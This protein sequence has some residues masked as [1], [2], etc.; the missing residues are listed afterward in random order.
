[1]RKV[2]ST[3]L[4]GFLM[5]L[6]LSATAAL[7]VNVQVSVD[8]KVAQ[9]GDNV[10]I[11]GTI[12]HD[13]GAGGDFGYRVYAV[14]PSRPDGGERVI[15]CDSGRLNTSDSSG[16]SYTC[17]LPTIDGFQSLGLLNA[18]DR[19]VI[20]LKVGVAAIDA[21][22]NSTGK[23]AKEVLVVNTQKIQDRLQNLEDNLD[24]FIN[25]SQDV[26]LRCDNIT[27]TAE[28]VGADD[29]AQKCSDLQDRIDQRIN[30]TLAAKERIAN[31]IANIGNLS[32][33]DFGD[34]KDRLMG[35]SLGAGQFKVDAGELGQLLQ[36]EKAKFEGA[37][38]RNIENQTMQRE[39]EIRQ[40]LADQRQQINDRI[41]TLNRKISGEGAAIG[42]TL[43]RNVTGP[44][45]FPNGGPGPKPSAEESAPSET[46]GA[47]DSMEMNE[48]GGAMQ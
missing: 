27:A 19:A 9:P 13:G 32:T 22:D 39:L 28:A 35:F 20:P 4:F 10:T 3:A 1:M 21:A 7:A 44:D 24:A 38:A 17:Q 37:I 36:T 41:Q 25:R 30:E 47:N 11:T 6:V 5:T 31:A 14:A 33:F 2:Q 18:A 15:V 43:A 48:S 40:K 29:V 23:D 46:A 34:L 26:S 12:T 8:Q 42:R 16:V 45:F